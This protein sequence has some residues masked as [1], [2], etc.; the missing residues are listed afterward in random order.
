MFAIKI[1]QVGKMK[2]GPL[3][4]LAQDLLKRLTPYARLEVRIVKELSESQTWWNDDSIK[5]LLSEKGKTL[6]S[7]AFAHALT[8]WSDHGQR[9]L[10]FVVA[11]PHGFS[12]EVL[13]HADH[14]LS[15]SPMTF[16]HEMAYVILLEQLYRAGTIL[17][18]KIYHY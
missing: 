18:G 13:A 14:V 7:V 8:K 12:K 4:E 10:T 1:V 9:S 6:D 16:T 5:I 3:A 2:N 17:A 15:L 11:G